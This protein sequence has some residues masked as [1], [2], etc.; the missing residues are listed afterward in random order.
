M[1]FG[2]QT[3]SSAHIIPAA[4]V[5]FK[6]YMRIRLYITTSSKKQQFATFSRTPSSA[7]MASFSGRGP[8]V[9]VLEIL[10]PDVTAPGVDILAAWTGERSPTGLSTDTRRV[11]F[12][13]ASGTSMACPHASGV[14]C[15]G[16]VRHAW[17]ASWKILA[18]ERKPKMTEKS[19]L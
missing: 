3:V 15:I 6:A 12:N 14:A 1:E 18:E 17:K 4:T 11:Q 2:E 5:T 10:K 7:R 9:Q 19:A 8:C 13:V 16:A